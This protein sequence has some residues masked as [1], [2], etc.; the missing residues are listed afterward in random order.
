MK[1][2]YDLEIGDI[3]EF[4]YKTDHGNLKVI[5]TKT[6]K[7]TFRDNIVIADNKTCEGDGVFKYTSARY[8]YIRYL[9]NTEDATK[10]FRDEFPEYFI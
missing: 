4:E 2:F 10:S 6:G 1:N 8:E 5:A 9:G 3:A 7:F